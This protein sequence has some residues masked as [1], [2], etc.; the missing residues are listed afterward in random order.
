MFLC[1]KKQ[2]FNQSIATTEKY[3][4]IHGTATE[5]F[6]F[7]NPWI[8]KANRS[9]QIQTHTSDQ[10]THEIHFLKI[11]REASDRDDSMCQR[12]L[13]EISLRLNL[14]RHTQSAASRG[15]KLQYTRARNTS[16]RELPRS[17]CISL[18]LRV[19]A[20]LSSWR[21]FYDLITFR[22]ICTS[23][24][25]SKEFVVLVI[26]LT[27]KISQ[28]LR[29]R[30]HLSWLPFWV[31]FSCYLLTYTSFPLKQSFEQYILGEN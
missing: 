20:F 25:S 16:R 29:E 2:H 9:K 6:W 31:C 4:L 28:E 3:K 24:G 21:S 26:S 14:S 30:L 23:H 19:G 7:S 17:N 8:F 27:N 5:H 15:G 13:S 12:Q 18:S 1:T 11:H 22:I 10:P